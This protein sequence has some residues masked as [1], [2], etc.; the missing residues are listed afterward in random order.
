MGQMFD[1]TCDQMNNWKGDNPGGG[2]D[3]VDLSNV[4]TTS[5]GKV[6]R[7]GEHLSWYGSYDRRA[8]IQPPSCWHYKPGRFLAVGPLNWEEIID[9]DDDDDNWPDPAAP[10]CGTNRP[11]NGNDNDDGES[12]EDMQD[13]E[14]RTGKGKGTKVGKGKGKAS[15]D[16]KGKGKGNG[17]GNG[18][19][20]G[21]VKRT[22]GGDDISRAIALQLHKEFSEADLDTDG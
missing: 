17:K 15:E 8:K 9:K 4:Q 22:P 20:K 14:E 13:G 16:R 2:R 3:H 21:I 1:I 18:K 5:L 7:I 10:G 19:G 12:E 11:S 6:K